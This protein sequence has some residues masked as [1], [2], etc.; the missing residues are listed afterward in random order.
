[1]FKKSILSILVLLIPLS[2]FGQEAKE[3]DMFLAAKEAYDLGSYSVSLDLLNKFIAQFPGS[4]AMPEAQL[5]LSQCL[6]Q[7]TPLKMMQLKH[8]L[9]LQPNTFFLNVFSAYQL[10][11]PCP[12]QIYVPQIALQKYLQGQRL[13][14]EE[15]R[16]VAD[17]K[18]RE[19]IEEARLKLEEDKLDLQDM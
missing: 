14:A 7:K 5:Y 16:Y 18:S 4:K 15:A 11:V 12:S 6:F 3:R 8:K 13:E 17:I 10:H 2:A 19:D 1:M 9:F